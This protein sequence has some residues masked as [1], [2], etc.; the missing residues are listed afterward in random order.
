MMGYIRHNAI[1]VTTWKPGEA[2]KVFDQA[3]SLFPGAVLGPSREMVNGYQTIL[4]CPDGSKEGWPRSDEGDRCR[5]E[6]KAWLR[7]QPYLE[8]AEIAYGDDDR[9]AQV[10]DSQWPA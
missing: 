6:F 4:V 5:G 10:V 9:S 7:D 2:L 8:W 3:E 1:I